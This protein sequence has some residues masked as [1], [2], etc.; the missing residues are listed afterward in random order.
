MTDNEIINALRC[1]VTGRCSTGECAYLGRDDVADCLE[2]SGI[3]ALNLILRQKAEIE[4][5][6]KQNRSVIEHLKKAR[7]QIKTAK[8]EAIKEFADR[9]LFE[10]RAG[11]F[12]YSHIRFIIKNLLKEMVGDNDG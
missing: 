1:C 4:R 12:G 7:R 11:V 10:F 2:Q 9:L 8:A 3:D 5:L 6:E